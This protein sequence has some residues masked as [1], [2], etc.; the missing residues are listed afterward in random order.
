MLIYPEVYLLEGGYCNFFESHPGLCAP[1]GYKKMWNV[2]KQR[3]LNYYNAN[4]QI[5]KKN[6]GSKH[7]DLRKDLVKEHIPTM[8]FN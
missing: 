1:R 6:F 8:F 3:S 7:E 2:E 5:W 4:P